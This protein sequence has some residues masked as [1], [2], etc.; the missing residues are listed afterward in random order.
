[1]V[2]G[3]RIKKVMSSFSCVP[4]I[5]KDFFVSQPVRGVQVPQIEIASILLQVVTKK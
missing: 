2:G 5:R 1:M 4:A 3:G